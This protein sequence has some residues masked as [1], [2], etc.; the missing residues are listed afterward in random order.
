MVQR[1]FHMF[2]AFQRYLNN[3]TY[4]DVIQ[5]FDQTIILKKACRHTMEQFFRHQFFLTLLI[6]EYFHFIFYLFF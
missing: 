2:M 6:M 3:F 5:A 4:N 1:S